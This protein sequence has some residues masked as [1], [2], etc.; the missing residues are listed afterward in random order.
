V[1]F[2]ITRLHILFNEL[3]SAEI[4]RLNVVVGNTNPA[5]V[6][7]LLRRVLPT[8]S[9]DDLDALSIHDR[10][11]VESEIMKERSMSNVVRVFDAPSPDCIQTSDE[12]VRDY[13]PPDFLL[14][15][16]LQRGY[17]YSMTAATGAGKTSLALLIAALVVT[18]KRL[19][20]IDV[21]K[22]Q[23]LY[24]AG[25]NPDD[26]R[27]RWFGI[28]QELKFAPAAVDVHWLAGAMNL[29]ENAERISQEVVRKGLKPSLVIVDTSAAYNF[30]DDEN[31]NAQQVGYARLLRTLTNLPG[32]PC[33]IVLCHPTK[34]AGDDALVPRGGYA[35]LCEV[36]GNFAVRKR[37]TT[38]TMAPLGKFR[39][40]E[41]WSLSF[42]LKK[43]YHPRL[44]DAKG[45]D[46][47]TV[48]AEPIT[49]A[50]KQ[51][52]TAQA[53]RH[54]DLVLK[55]VETHPKASLTE[56]A[57][58]LCWRNGK[59]APDKTRVNRALETLMQEKFIRKHRDEW[60]LTQAGEK[61][62][63]RLDLGPRPSAVLNP[64]FP[65]VSA[66]ETVH[67]PLPPTNRG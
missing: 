41:N 51:Q 25:E 40:D 67:P 59:G 45:R 5:A 34:T 16:I 50:Q 37:E 35:F 8:I 62:L 27:G 14:D 10:L 39:G 15:G 26:V 3:D 7:A 21:D 23:V 52:M 60:Q 54:E 64:M 30:G 13:V 49:D 4:D 55:T 24:L 48:V 9:N 6:E 65:T 44:K 2:S 31:S 20:E 11:R 22:G 17:F 29:S 46:I 61:E 58:S 1:L 33:V 18:G 47:S 57:T 28:S 36:D 53:R 63:N 19:G 32:R 56:R 43:V 12:F 66:P 38:I 42:A